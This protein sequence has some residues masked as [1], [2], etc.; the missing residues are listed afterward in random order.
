[1]PDAVT[2]LTISLVVC[3]LLQ[4]IAVLIRLRGPRGFVRNIDWDRVSDPQGLGHFVALMMSVLGALIAAHG[5]AVYAFHDAPP[6]RNAAT[7]AF[8]VLLALA[9]LALLVGQLRYQDKPKRDE[10]R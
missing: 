5:V 7:T 9:V 2:A 1:M 10:R 3:A 4:T 6:L 8:V